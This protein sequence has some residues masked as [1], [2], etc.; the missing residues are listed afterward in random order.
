MVMRDPPFSHTQLLVF[1]ALLGVW[2]QQERAQDGKN[3][4]F[5]A[6]KRVRVKRLIGDSVVVPAEEH[7]YTASE[8][9]K[10]RFLLLRHEK[11]AFTKACFPARLR[12]SHGC[13]VYDESNTNS[14][15]KVKRVLIWFGLE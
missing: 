14:N 13:V 12:E 8:D 9:V 10:A 6:E 15:S 7:S 1:T 5:D 2:Q 11:A 4:N 3:R